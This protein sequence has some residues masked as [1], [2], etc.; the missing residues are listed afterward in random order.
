[1][2]GLTLPER[3]LPAGVVPPGPTSGCDWIAY[4]M[5]DWD[6][7]GSDFRIRDWS[8]RTRGAPPPATLTQAYAQPGR[9]TI[10]VR[11]IDLLGGVTTATLA[12]DL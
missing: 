8:G 7:T 12:V 9:H 3:E 4:W 1:M 10:A 11:A 6:Y 5:V 2:N